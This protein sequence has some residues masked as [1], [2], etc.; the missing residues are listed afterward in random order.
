[1]RAKNLTFNYLKT[2]G[3]SSQK[4]HKPMILENVYTGAHSYAVSTRSLVDFSFCF[5]EAMLNYR[6]DGSPL[7]VMC[8]KAQRPALC[9]LS[10]RSRGPWPEGAHSVPVTVVMNALTSNSCSLASLQPGRE[11]LRWQGQGHRG[12][13][14][15]GEIQR[16]RPKLQDR[17]VCSSQKSP[18]KPQS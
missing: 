17:Q 16:C 10:A 4:C 5:C 18:T 8:D 3:E 2:R 7:P 11:D 9:E 6:G 1:M 12:S 15:K 13:G 14:G